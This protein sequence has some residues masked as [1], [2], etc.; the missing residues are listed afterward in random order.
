MSRAAATVKRVK[1][2][3][4]GKSPLI[5]F[6]DADIHKAAI[7]AAIMGSLNSGQFCAAPTRFY[8]HEKV[9]D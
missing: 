9:H 4:G 6:D 3:L 5:V 2:E 8:I 1:L 7:V